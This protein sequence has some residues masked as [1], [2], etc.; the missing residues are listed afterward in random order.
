MAED[1]PDIGA[2]HDINSS[3][4]IK[5]FASYTQMTLAGTVLSAGMLA[6]EAKMSLDPLP[7]N[8]LTLSQGLP[9]MGP[10][11][12]LTAT[13]ITI[14][15]GGPVGAKIELSPTGITLSFGPPGAGS[16]IKLDA[17]GVTLQAGP[18]NKL[19]LL[20]AGLDVTSAKIGLTSPGSYQLVCSDLSETAGKV[21]RVGGMTTMV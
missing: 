19:A 15:F 4:I 14:Q 13:G 16:S 7:V 9:P 17:L 3:P 1:D 11:I 6:T 5:N 20:Q 2:T 8:G 10:T 21:T 12:A 18:L